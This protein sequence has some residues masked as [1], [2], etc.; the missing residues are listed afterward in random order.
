VICFSISTSPHD[1]I[2]RKPTAPELYSHPL[3]YWIFVPELKKKSVCKI[4]SL[5]RAKFLFILLWQIVCWF[6]TARNVKPYDAYVWATLANKA[7]W[8]WFY[9]YFNLITVTCN[10]VSFQAAVIKMDI[11]YYGLKLEGKKQ[12]SIQ[13]RSLIGKEQMPVISKCY[14]QITRLSS[15]IPTT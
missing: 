15:D 10:K 4:T 2:S 11:C 3:S 13:E 5:L 6:K 7:Y 8:H 12:R 14:Y 9:Q 1:V